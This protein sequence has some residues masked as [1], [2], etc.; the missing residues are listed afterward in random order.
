M[1]PIC[2]RLKVYYKKKTFQ[3]LLYKVGLQI[4][5][6]V[7]AP[8]IKQKTA[9][10]LVHKEIEASMATLVNEEIKVVMLC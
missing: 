5:F 6:H 4:F 1:E 8:L 3:S 10:M 9:A 7:T 2:A